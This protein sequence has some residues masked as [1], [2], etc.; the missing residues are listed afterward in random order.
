MRWHRASG[1]PLRKRRA[2]R[3]SSRCP[4]RTRTGTPA[5][6]AAAGRG[7]SA[8]SP[9]L[10]R[11]RGR[12][13]RTPSD[14]SSH[15]A[16]PQAVASA[17]PAAPRDAH[18]PPGFPLWRR[19]TPPAPRGTTGWV[20][21]RRRPRGAEGSRPPSRAA[22]AGCTPP[23]RGA[24]CSSRRRGP[25]PASGRAAAAP[26][27]PSLPARTPRWRCCTRRRWARPRG[28]RRASSRC[29]TPSRTVAVASHSPSRAGSSS[30]PAARRAWRAAAPTA[31]SSARAGRRG[32]SRPSRR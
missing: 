26:A 15:R 31:R 8:A 7:C 27:R 14:K 9:V 6:R 25:P 28:R 32:G 24:A 16:R 21:S 20:A 3:C 13:P 30:G 18:S 4:R 11:P 23:S 1:L 29:R 17:R 12:T 22:P 10:S 5:S 2:R 19:S